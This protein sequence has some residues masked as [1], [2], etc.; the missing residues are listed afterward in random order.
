LK[1]TGRSLILCGACHQPARIMRQAD[2]VEHIGEKNIV[3]HVEAALTRAREIQAGFSGL[4][5]QA[6]SDMVLL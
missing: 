4:G 2:F 3:S 5:E 6:A 1:K